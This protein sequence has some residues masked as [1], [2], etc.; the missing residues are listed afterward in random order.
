MHQ[1]PSGGWALHSALP[2]PPSHIRGWDGTSERGKGGKGEGTGT[3]PHTC[4]ATGLAHSD[5]VHFLVA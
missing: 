1:K 5:V 4:L 2:R 3:L